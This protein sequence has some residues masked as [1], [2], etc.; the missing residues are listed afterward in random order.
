MGSSIA[1]VKDFS[2]SSSNSTGGGGQTGSATVI[3]NLNLFVFGGRVQKDD[4]AKVPSSDISICTLEG[5][6][7]SIVFFS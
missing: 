5:T 4:G 7:C 2:L 1:L 3:Q 6:A